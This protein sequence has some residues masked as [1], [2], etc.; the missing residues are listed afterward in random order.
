MPTGRKTP[1]Q[2]SANVMN[3]TWGLVLPILATKRSVR[4][5]G[6][7]LILRMQHRLSAEL[8]D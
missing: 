7:G 1:T 4:I 3:M 8:S 6:F 2:P 5:D